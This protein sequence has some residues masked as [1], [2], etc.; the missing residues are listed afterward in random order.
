MSPSLA[1]AWIASI[2]LEKKGALALSLIL[3]FAVKRKEI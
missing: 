1:K 3:V 2:F